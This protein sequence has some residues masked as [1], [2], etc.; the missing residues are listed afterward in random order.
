MQDQSLMKARSIY[1]N[2]FSKFFV[3]SKDV[4]VYFELINILKLLE[5]N[6]LDVTTGEAVSRILSKLDSSSNVALVQ[7]Y[8]DIFHNP[9]TKNIRTTASYYD[10][11]VESGKKRVEM[12]QF[13]AKTKIRR[14]ESEFAEY[15][16][17]IGFILT[18]MAELNELIVNGEEEYKNTQHCIFEEILNDFIE[19]F[20]KDVYEHEC[21]DIFKDVIIVLKAFIEFE[22]LYLQ[23]SKPSP[24]EEIVREVESCDVISDEEA[25]R[26]ARNKAMKANGPK[27]EDADPEK[28]A[29]DVE[30]E[31]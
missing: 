13:L 4:T 2:L 30:S 11:G 10:E 8:D 14:N 16:D 23:V 17:S 29:Y 15:E 20:A 6:P 22:R 7:E 24:R 9:E 31:V 1:Y 12:L 21:A 19:D 28:I 5:K 3:Y 25:Q 26:R 27:I 18:L